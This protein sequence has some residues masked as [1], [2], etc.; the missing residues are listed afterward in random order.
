[1]VEVG[2][3]TLEIS[4][5]RFVST[6][7]VVTLDAVVGVGAAIVEVGV[8]VDGW[9]EGAACSGV[10]AVGLD[11][12]TMGAAVVDGVGRELATEVDPI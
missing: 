6:G 5:F 9:V 3:E 11:L 1:M 4:G 10:E 7:L 8:D 12:V 2:V